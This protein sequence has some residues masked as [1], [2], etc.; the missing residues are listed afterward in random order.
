[1]AKHIHIHVNDTF[2]E[3]D[4]PRGTG[5]KGG[6]FVT[7]GAA[8][9]TAGHHEARA[10][11]HR[12]AAKKKGADHPEHQAHHAAA[13]SHERAAMFLRA[14]SG[15]RPP[16]AGTHDPA[17]VA[18]KNANEAAEH[19]AKISKPSGNPNKAAALEA[20]RK[21]KAGD[22]E[23]ADKKAEALKSHKMYSKSDYDYLSEKGYDADE[24]KVLWDRDTKA[25]HG[26]VQHREI[27]DVVGHLFGKA[28]K[29]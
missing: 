19:E 12:S 5:A 29:E 8:G 24:I 3:K 2:N 1:M 23:E 21:A 25:G 15:D 18:Q 27:P 16:V 10:E 4:H 9:G 17:G 13:F 26:P 28:K 14:A 20:A 6:Q 22:K 7:K 11:E